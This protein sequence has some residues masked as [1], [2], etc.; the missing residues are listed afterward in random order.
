LAGL[1]SPRHRTGQAGWTD[2]LAGRP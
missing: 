1:G 2:R